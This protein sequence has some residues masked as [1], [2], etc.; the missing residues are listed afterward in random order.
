MSLKAR[1]VILFTLFVAIVLAI[2]MAVIYFLYYNYRVEDFYERI[3][4]TTLFIYDE[5][6]NIK[7]AGQSKQFAT[8]S[9][10]QQTV[11][12]NE[13][14][15]IIDSNFNRIFS[16]GRGD[17][18]QID[19]AY[20]KKFGTF[21]KPFRF[22]QNE[23]ECIG[24]YVPQQ[25]LYVFASAFDKYGLRKLNNLKLILAGVFFGGLLLT[26][27]FSF[28]FVRQILRP[29]KKLG[30]QMKITTEQNMTGRVYEGKNKDELTEI[31]KNFN[32]MLGRLDKAFEIQKSFVHHA[33]HELRT[34][35]ATMLSQ[36]ELALSKNDIDAAAYKKTL[37]SLHEDQQHMIALTNSLLL[38]SQYE[39]IAFSLEWE[40]KRIDEL[41]YEEVDGMNKSYA[42]AVI[43][44]N[45]A[46]IPE[47]EYLVRRCNEALIKSAFSNLIRNAYQYSEDKMVNITIDA[48]SK[49]MNICFENKGKNLSADEQERL[50][51][52]F[53]R[54]T[55]SVNKK[56]F[57]VG[58]SIVER[59]AQV[60]NGTITYAI[61]PNN[62]N[63]FC[64][65]L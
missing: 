21:N 33:S 28:F 55:N 7:E 41:L 19:K 12:Y 48:T 30:E 10:N 22:K 2:S 60:H 31:A 50:F 23:F 24:I 54:G 42:D 5:Y 26:S 63:R 9:L 13:K 8:S 36:T 32:A 64:F 61:A 4:R 39:K 51:V 59:I 62:N 47:E 37:E 57:G 15:V 52:P 65:S 14:V 6:N 16:E 44:V 46:Q 43:S 11:L 29:L 17:E 45:Y 20:Y 1:F 3:H 56:G 38:L 35:L 27:V 58:L 53:F 18:I 40:F 34:P 49:Q 25:K